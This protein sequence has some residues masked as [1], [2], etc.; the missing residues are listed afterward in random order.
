MTYLT[1]DYTDHK[2]SNFFS[3]VSFFL[4]VD[5]NDGTVMVDRI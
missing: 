2:G 1:G 4:V 3:L 5:H